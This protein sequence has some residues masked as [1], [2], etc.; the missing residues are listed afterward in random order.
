MLTLTL[1]KWRVFTYAD[2]YILFMWSNL[3]LHIGTLA[4]VCSVIN[5]LSSIF[6]FSVVFASFVICH[7]FFS[8]RLHK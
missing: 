8:K 4:I 6:D 5:V 2:F 7:V 1:I 3:F